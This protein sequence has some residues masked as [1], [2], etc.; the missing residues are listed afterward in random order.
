MMLSLGYNRTLRYEDLDYVGSTED[1]VEKNK[2]LL[3]FTADAA[4]KKVIQFLT[5]KNSYKLIIAETPEDVKRELVERIFNLAIIDCE[6][7]NQD[8]YELVFEIRSDGG[9]ME[10]L[11]IIGLAS[12]HTATLPRPGEVGLTEIVKKPMNIAKFGQ[13]LSKQLA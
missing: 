11:P 3:L 4:T 10:T 7:K 13:E 1:A 6:Q 5:N 2:Y 8:G 9:R 12:S